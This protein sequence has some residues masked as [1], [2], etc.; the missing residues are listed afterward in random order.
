MKKWIFSLLLA[1]TDCLAVSAQEAD[2]SP[3][4]LPEPFSERASLL[5]PHRSE[6]NEDRVESEARFVW[7]RVLLHRRDDA[8]AIRQFQRAWRAETRRAW[9]VARD[10]QAAETWWSYGRGGALRQAGSCKFAN[11][12]RFGGT[13]GRRLE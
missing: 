10:R 9:L 12:S 2:Q 3:G 6:Q 11:R 8:R 13:A 5:S 7:G 1:L 4:R